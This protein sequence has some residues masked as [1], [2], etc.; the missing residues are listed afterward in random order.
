MRP[1]ALLTLLALL[2]PALAGEPAPAP[3]VVTVTETTTITYA[4][5]RPRVE[6]GETVLF[7]VGVP[8]PAGYVALS[9]PPA[10]VAKGLWRGF[11]KGT[12]AVMERLAEKVAPSAYQARWTHPPGLRSH[13]MG[14][15]H[16]VP[17]SVLERMTTDEMLKMHDALHDAARAKGAGTLPRYSVPAPVRAPVVQQYQFQRTIQ[18]SL[19]QSAPGCPGGVCPTPARR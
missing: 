10:G 18:Y 16:G 2:T 8:A 19:P 6:A 13:L 11:R 12:A 9:D 17:A 4:A 5:L 3:R 15:M 14:E 1:T 7:A